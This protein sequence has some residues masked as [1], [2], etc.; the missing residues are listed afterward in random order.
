MSSTTASVYDVCPFDIVSKIKKMTLGT[1]EFKKKLRHK[2][3]QIKTWQH[4]HV[5]QV[6]HYN[7]S[8]NNMN[9]QDCL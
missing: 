9:I 3:I 4:K 7:F 1:W 8:I 5:D 6:G 2:K